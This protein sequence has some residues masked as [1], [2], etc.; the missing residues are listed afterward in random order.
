MIADIIYNEDCMKTMSRMPDNSIDLIVTSPPYN[1]WGFRRNSKRK[2]Y[3][4]FDDKMSETEY[5]QWVSEVIAQCARVLKEG[6]AMYWNHK[7]RFEKKTYKHVFWLVEICPLNLFQHIVWHYPSSPDVA[8]IKWYPRHEEILM[9]T[10]GEPQ[11]FDEDMCKLGDVWDIS[12]M[13]KNDHPAP[14][15]IEIPLRAIKASCPPGGIV[16][17]PFM[18]SGTTAMATISVGEGRR[19]I[20]SE[21][22]ETYCKLSQERVECEKRCLKLF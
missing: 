21:I 7:G 22:S 19:Y 16:Y 6:G 17:D 2:S 10:K 18:G 20:G 4:G 3:D 13:Q 14:F 1:F 8:K 5:K 15:P 9:F 11:Y 12:H